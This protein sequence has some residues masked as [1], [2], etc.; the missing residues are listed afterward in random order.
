MISTALCG[1]EAVLM[2]QDEGFLFIVR[3]AA[4]EM[5]SGRPISGPRP[6]VDRVMLMLWICRWS[7]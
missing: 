7:V 3:C 4:V 6:E 5:P 2:K 1:S